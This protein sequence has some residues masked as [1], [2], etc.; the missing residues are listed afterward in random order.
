MLSFTLYIG[1]SNTVITKV[2]VPIHP[3]PSVKVCVIVC[4]PVPAAMGSKIPPVTPDPK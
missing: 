2:Q 1:G 4:A 3:N